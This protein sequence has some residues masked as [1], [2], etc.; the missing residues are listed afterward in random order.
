MRKNVNFSTYQKVKEFFE[1]NKGKKFNKTKIRD[2]T[3]V[4]YESV[5]LII[6]SLHKERFI[7]KVKSEYWRE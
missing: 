5:K 4:D 2:E 3:N 6:E 7:K 1:K